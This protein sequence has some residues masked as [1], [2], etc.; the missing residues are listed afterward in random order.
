MMTLELQLP[1]I[2]QVRNQQRPDVLTA[3]LPPTSEL[4]FDH[5]LQRRYIRFVYNH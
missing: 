5:S 4:G 2:P 3:V 1:L